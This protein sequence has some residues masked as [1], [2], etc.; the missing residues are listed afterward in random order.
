[1]AILMSLAAAVAFGASDFLAGLRSRLLGPFLVVTV[2]QFA[3]AV[4]LLLALTG[5]RVGPSGP[6]LAWG[7][8]AGAGM[9]VG[10]LA[11]YR[12]LGIGRMNV[13]A[14]LSGLGAAG[15]PVLAGLSFG[16]RLSW[17]AGVGI[18]VALGAV[19]LVT[20]GSSDETHGEANERLGV[21]EGMVA[22]VGLAVM[23]I[24]FERGGTDHGIWPLITAQAAAIGLLV[25]FG[26]TTGRRMRPTRRELPALLVAGVLVTA[27]NLL[28][29][30]ATG[31]G[32]LAVVAVVTS[33]YP[34]GPV[35]LAALMLGERASRTQLVGLAAAAVAVVMIAA[36]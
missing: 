18:L 22:G 21:P 33:L 23:L 30:L 17:L 14:P 25:G 4:F 2:G 28:F 36:G 29:L 9:A 10:L 1:M 35:V 3:G 12:G 31:H 32:E 15:L 20:A 13:V 8:V 7:A 11:L 26:L 16:E 6:A 34:A 19:L 5:F 27:A 24:G